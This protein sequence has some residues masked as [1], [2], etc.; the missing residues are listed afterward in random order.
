MLHHYCVWS[1]AA[2]EFQGKSGVEVSS[3]DTT[4]MLYGLL[5]CSQYFGGATAVDYAWSCH[6]IR[7]RDWIE[8]NT[9]GHLNQVRMAYTPGVGFA[10]N[11]WDQRSDETTLVS[12]MAAMGDTNL[13]ARVLWRAWS[14]TPAVMSPRLPTASVASPR[15]SAIPSPTS[16]R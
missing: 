12:I 7:W 10:A 2:Q 8:T 13:D 6:H 1:D 4:L 15:G 5:V 3:I 11:W 16:M 14:R 9:V